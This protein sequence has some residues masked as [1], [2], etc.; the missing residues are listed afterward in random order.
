[1]NLANVSGATRRTFLKATGALGAALAL[2]PEQFGLAPLGHA[3]AVEPRAGGE[4][5]IPTFC[6]M[7]GPSS[8][9][10]ILAKVVDGK[11]VGIEPFPE[12]PTN[13]GVN[14]AKAHAAPQWVYSPDRLRYPLK[15]VGKKGE[16]KF[17]RISWDEALTIIADKLKEQKALY[18]PESLAIL[19]P[20]RRSYSEY[21][22]RFLMTHGS[23]NYGHSGICA[24][25]RRFSFTYTVGGEVPADYAH[26][27]LMIIWGKQ[28]IFSGAAKHTVDTLL[29]AKERGCKFIAIKPTV[30]PDGAVTNAQWVPL[31]PGTDAALA[32]AMLHVVINEKLYDA[33]FVKNWC[34]GFDQFKEHVQQYTPEWAEKITGVPAA[35][36]QE[37]ARVYAT[38]PNASIDCGNGPEHCPASNDAFRAIAALIAITGHLATSGGAGGGPGPGGGMAS[39]RGVHLAERYTQEWVDKLVGYEFPAAFQ[40]TFEG[41]SASYYRILDS[42]LTGKKYPIRTIIA[43]GTQALASTRGTRRMIEALKKLDFFVVLDV[44]R[45]SDMPYADVVIPIS[46]MYETDHPF[47][48]SGNWIMARNKVIEPLGETK[49][50]Y[51]FWVEL[52]NK[53]GYGADWWSGDFKKHMD[54]RMEPLGMTYEELRTKYPKGYSPSAGSTSQAAPFGASPAAQPASSSAAS[55]LDQQYVRRFSGKSA[56]IDK[57]PYLPEGKVALYN[58]SFEKAGLTPMPVWRELPEGPTATPELL[59]KYPLLL[60]DYHTSRAYNAS[61]LRNVPYLREQ[62]PYPFLHI[63][64]DTAKERGIAD[65]DWVKVEGPHGAMKVKAMIYPGTRPDVVMMLHGWWQGCQE[66][67]MEDFPIADGGANTNNMYTTDP[68]KMFD[69]VITAMSSQTLV[70][71]RKA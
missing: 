55:S 57:T 27:D 42:V 47:E 31:R 69:P 24:M 30:E 48:S 18:G 46:T 16:G 17:Q 9:C 4:K 65:G 39:P 45:T 50:D 63:H 1:M 8:G 44:T 52:G 3:A 66:L 15:R 20:A 19:S 21:L 40:P 59:K 62:E 2:G 25:Q 56:T 6:A 34:Y 37:V 38:T 58:T 28:P 60:S 64:P 36:I 14:C 43:P 11:F 26:A 10:G 54:W 61:W 29:A 32:L 13:G 53:M 12:C 49:S 70:Q 67:G 35:Q 7:C 71:V 22:Y 33:E 41:T 51:E 5:L 23:P 68:E